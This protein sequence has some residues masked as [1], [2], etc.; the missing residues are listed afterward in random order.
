MGFHIL[1]GVMILHK[2]LCEELEIPSIQQDNWQ[3]M[4][5]TV[6]PNKMLGS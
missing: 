5:I 6:L 2:I 3:C 1:N 4:L